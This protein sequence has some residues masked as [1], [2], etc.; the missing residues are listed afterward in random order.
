[1]GCIHLNQLRLIWLLLLSLIN[2]L[3]PANANSDL[4]TKDL[5]NATTT[6]QNK[7]NTADGKNITLFSAV[8]LT[9]LH[10]P[11]LAALAKEISALERATLQAPLFRNPK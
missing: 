7:L 4:F 11:E 6:E 9:L 2:F 3:Q 1:M 5:E 10:N 8:T